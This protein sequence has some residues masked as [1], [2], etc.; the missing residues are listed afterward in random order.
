MASPRAMRPYGRRGGFSSAAARCQGQAFR[1]SG[2]RIA[3][4]GPDHD[5]AAA[6]Q[7]VNTLRLEARAALG[8]E[9]TDLAIG[10]CVWRSGEDG[11]LVIERALIAAEQAQQATTLDPDRT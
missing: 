11:E 1:A 9:R 8:D 2:R 4:L 5:Q 6:D 3:L 7:T 10:A